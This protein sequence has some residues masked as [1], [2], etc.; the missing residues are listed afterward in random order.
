MKT[1]QEAATQ[2]RAEATIR[3]LDRIKDIK[4]VTPDAYRDEIAGA[5]VDEML[6]WLEE[7]TFPELLAPYPALFRF[8]IG[9]LR[10]KT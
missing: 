3:V 8:I 9:Q 5:A 7:L 10:R 6:A 1:I 4:G 2:L